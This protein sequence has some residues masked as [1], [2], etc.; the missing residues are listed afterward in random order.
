MLVKELQALGL[1]MKVLDA[2]QQE[3]EL[4]DLDEDNDHN[5][6]GDALQKVAD[7]QEKKRQNDAAAS[8]TL[9]DMMNSGNEN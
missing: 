1:D 5:F 7:E 9:A 3:I 6:A 4:R 2:D 8:Q